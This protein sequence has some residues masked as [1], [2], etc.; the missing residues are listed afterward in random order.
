MSTVTTN[1][2]D[3]QNLA[4]NGII[5]DCNLTITSGSFTV[6]VGRNGSGKSSLL[7]CLSGWNKIDS[8]ELR[9]KSIPLNQ[10]APK[11]RAA[12]I[13]LLPQRISVSENL[14]IKEWLSQFRF[15]FNESKRVTDGIITNALTA[16]QLEELSNRTWPQLSGG[17]AQRLALLGLTLQET[18]CW[19]LDEPGN[20]LDPSVTHQLYQMLISQW[21][22][23][24]AIVLV[25]HN[26]NVLLQHLPRELWSSVRVAGMEQGHIQWLTSLADDTL[27]SNLGTVYGLHGH[28]VE[29]GNTKQIFYLRNQS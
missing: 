6:I 2:I 16:F 3:A 14:P 22:N 29:V 12:V 10:Y 26:I 15:R 28:F 25:T 24:I 13:G 21:Q 4:W 7:R 27:P 8:G 9:L 20:H 17:E 5:R 11:S 19:L 1:L 23:G 18:E